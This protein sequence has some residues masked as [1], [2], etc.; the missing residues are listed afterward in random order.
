M[1]VLPELCVCLCVSFKVLEMKRLPIPRE[2][3]R[4]FECGFNSVVPGKVRFA[5]DCW[6]PLVRMGL[7]V[8]RFARAARRQR[9]FQGKCCLPACPR[10]RKRERWILAPTSPREGGKV[11]LGPCV[12]R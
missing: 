8:C 9:G 2:K 3:G 10:S 7:I 12:G 5:D 11:G 4:G 1:K 6:L